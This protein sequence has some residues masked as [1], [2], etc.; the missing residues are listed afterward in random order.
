MR[1]NCKEEH[2]KK[3]MKW[4]EYFTTINR[5]WVLCHT[6]KPYCLVK[7]QDENELPKRARVIEI[8]RIFTTIKYTCIMSYN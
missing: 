4:V 6:I 5:R 2:V 3:S 8:S 1:Q 7:G